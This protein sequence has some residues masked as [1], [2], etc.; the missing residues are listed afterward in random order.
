[1]AFFSFVVAFFDAMVPPPTRMA[2]MGRHDAYMQFPLQCKQP[3]LP[4]VS[5]FDS[6]MLPVRA[7][8][9]REFGV[10]IF[11]ID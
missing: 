11:T 3:G 2:Q 4:L 8:R 1:L 6:F 7:D 9:S 5:R 10:E